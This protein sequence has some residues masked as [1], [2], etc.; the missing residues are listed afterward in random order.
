M[1]VGVQALAGAIRSAAGSVACTPEP[2]MKVGLSVVGVVAE[3]H[4]AALRKHP[5]A[6]HRGRPCVRAVLHPLPATAVTQHDVRA[7]G[8][9]HSTMTEGP[10]QGPWESPLPPQRC[11]PASRTCPCPEPQNRLG[12]GQQWGV[13]CTPMRDSEFSQKQEG[14]SHGELVHT[15]GLRW[16]YISTWG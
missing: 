8:W 3:I 5:E 7:A 6:G 10:L 9:G 15:W 11:T 12:I 14:K 16:G 2:L 13:Q 1:G 4:E